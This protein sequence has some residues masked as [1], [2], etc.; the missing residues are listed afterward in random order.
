MNT[1]GIGNDK[2]RGR[3]N[4][5]DDKAKYKNSSL[6]DAKKVSV[7]DIPL[8]NFHTLAELNI[9]INLTISIQNLQRYEKREK[10]HRSID[11]LHLRIPNFNEDRIDLSQLFS[12]RKV[13]KLQF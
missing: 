5:T 6:Q 3:F 2:F 1:S 12:Q 10:I 7:S 9:Y 11:L 8:L 4:K 13:K